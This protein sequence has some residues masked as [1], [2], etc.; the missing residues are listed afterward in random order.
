MT[1]DRKIDMYQ[2]KKLFIDGISKV[3]EIEA[4]QSN[5]KKIEY[6]VL[7]KVIDESTTD[8]REFVIIT[9]VGGAKSI[10]TITGNSNNANFKEIG[11]LINGGYYDE[12][13]YHESLL[14]NGYTAVEL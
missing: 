13:E 14:T 12:I 7:T 4:L 3:F 10:R 11:N 2:H 9:F 5:V 1:T 6:E 8:Y